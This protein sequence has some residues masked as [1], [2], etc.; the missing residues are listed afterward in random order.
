M[1][2]LLPGPK[3]LGLKFDMPNRKIMGSKSNCTSR[4]SECLRFL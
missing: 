4:L 2:E 3:Y 1:A